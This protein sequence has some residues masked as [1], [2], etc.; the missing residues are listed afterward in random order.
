MKTKE[1]KS[2]IISFARGSIWNFSSRLYFLY[3]R[4]DLASFFLAIVDLIRLSGT[5][6]YID[7][8]AEP[9]VSFL[10]AYIFTKAICSFFYLKSRGWIH[11]N[12]DCI[13]I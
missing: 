5:Q 4:S 7:I 3:K 1:R 13:A 9:Y 12:E 10:R 2:V 6:L 11:R 8:F